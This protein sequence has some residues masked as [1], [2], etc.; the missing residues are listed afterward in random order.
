MDFN[1]TY[2]GKLKFYY[3][4]KKFGF[5]QSDEFGELFFFDPDFMYK[6]I[7][8]E[9]D[10]C[11]QITKS[12][13]YEEK[14]EA[15]KVRKLYTSNNGI[16]VIDRVRSH[17]HN[18]SEKVLAEAISIMDV[19]VGET[20]VKLEVDLQKTIG[21]K[22]CVQINNENE[23]IYAVRKGR[24]EH[25]KFVKDAEMEETSI[26]TFVLMKAENED[27]YII[28]SAYAGEMT[29]VEPWDSRADENAI[30]FW[31]SHA[32]VYQP[33]EIFEETIVTEYSWNN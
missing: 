10:V 24:E 22:R 26:V 21:I 3:H 2:F 16:M 33:D 17:V 27:Y 18:L 13:K 1:K 6:N 5:L 29:E 11:F 23:I 14:I 9:D 32:L 12:R 31:E 15:T 20:L 25:S 7:N 28:L 19:E 30:N 8:D 4:S